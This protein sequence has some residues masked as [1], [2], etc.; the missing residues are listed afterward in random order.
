MNDHVVRPVWE[1]MLHCRLP[2]HHLLKVS[3]DFAADGA[4]TEPLL[5]DADDVMLVLCSS[6]WGILGK[7]FAAPGASLVACY[8]T[9]VKVLSETSVTVHGVQF[10]K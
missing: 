10:G 9:T 6:G 3:K 1:P 4:L 2:T 5:L 7:E 8:G